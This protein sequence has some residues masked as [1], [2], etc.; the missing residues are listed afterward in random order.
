[1][2]MIKIFKKHYHISIEN[3]CFFKLLSKVLTNNNYHNSYLFG[4]LY[5]SG[6][7]LNKNIDLIN[8]FSKAGNIT[9][10]QTKYFIHNNEIYHQTCH[11][12]RILYYDGDRL[13]ALAL[14]SNPREVDA[15]KNMDDIK[16]DVDFNF[17][18]IE[19]IETYKIAENL[20]LVK[21]ISV[22]NHDDFPNLHIKSLETKEQ[23]LDRIKN[24]ENLEHII[25]IIEK[26]P[27]FKKEDIDS[28]FHLFPCLDTIYQENVLEGRIEENK[29][30]YENFIKRLPDTYKSKFSNEEYFKNLIKKS[31]E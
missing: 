11:H 10:N 29:A 16:N 13:C 30:N 25:Q 24:L 28:H 2:I 9:K 17:S 27:D 19:K 21:R 31:D 15:L 12:N 26:D 5:K 6:K 22:L 7:L 20:Y 1:M 4:D 14:T 18:K 23:V 8:R 3:K